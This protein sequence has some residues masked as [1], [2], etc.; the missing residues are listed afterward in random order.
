MD[1]P[2]SREDKDKDPF[3][4]AKEAEAR[5][6][7]LQADVH[8]LKQRIQLSESEE[9]A[10][11]EE[12]DKKIN[13]NK[14]RIKKLESQLEE[15][16]ISKNKGLRGDER[17]I[18]KAFRKHSRE[19]GI[20]AGKSGKEAVEILDGK[21]L[22]LI[23]RSNALSHDLKVKERRLASLKEKSKDMAWS[24]YNEFELDAPESQTMH[25]IRELENEYQKV[26]KNLMECQ[27][28]NGKYKAIQEQ[29]KRELDAYPTLLEE[30]ENEYREQRT[31]IER[32]VASEEKA[33]ERRER[34]RKELSVIESQALKA[35]QEKERIIA[36]FNKALKPKQMST[37]RKSV[38]L[39]DTTAAEGWRN[40]REEQEKE[41]K[42]FHE[43]FEKI[44]EAIG[45]SDINDAEERFIT[46]KNTQEELNELVKR[47]EKRL[48]EMREET[49]E[50][51]SRN[52][53]LRGA[54]LAA[55]QVIL[56]EE[57]EKAKLKQEEQQRRKRAAETELER[58]IKLSADI[59][60]GLWYQLQLM[61]KYMR[62][63]EETIV[64]TPPD[65]EVLGIVTKMEAMLEVMQ[66]KL[67]G[68]DI[69][70]LKKKLAE[71]QFLQKVETVKLL[72]TPGRRIK[73]AEEEESSDDEDFEKK[74]SNLKKEAQIYA[75]MK[76]K[77]QGRGR[78]MML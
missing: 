30:L 1:K 40:L 14:D 36:E 68:E 53:S 49:K 20:I 60:S 62:E 72:P 77:Q 28:T 39:R 69:E 78:M 9:R 13:E 37:E 73:A 58:I 38:E 23:K 52:E 48:E 51:Q 42:K 12:C 63:D 59:K 46:Q 3:Q 10:E 70:E 34:A 11:K 21:I 17:I 43:A 55:P 65:T 45:I 33:Q 66:E 67:K 26:E 6:L 76:K 18:A 44:K 2:K 5:I 24:I 29:L 74:R 27:V 47:A 56:E 19:I 64:T 7:K 61:E 4:A 57:L 35:R 16:Q 32:L 22:D 31:D 50:L 75:E 54:E 71:E 15:L 8:H 25:R 41:L